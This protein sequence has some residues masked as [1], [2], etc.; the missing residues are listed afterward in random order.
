MSIIKF[1]FK[2]KYKHQ[3]LNQNLFKILSIYRRLNYA[4]FLSFD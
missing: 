4:L 2:E 1:L 3:K